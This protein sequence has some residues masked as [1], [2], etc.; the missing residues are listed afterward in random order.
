MEG[1]KLENKPMFDLSTETYT[2]CYCEEN[3]YKLCEKFLS[4]INP[5]SNDLNA[6]E[7]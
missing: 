1:A 7:H 6:R 4:R 5:A 3:V 2:S